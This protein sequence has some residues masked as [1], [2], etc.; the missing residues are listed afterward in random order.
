MF[1]CSR[2]LFTENQFKLPGDQDWGFWCVSYLWR[3]RTLKKNQER[4]NSL[5]ING[6]SLQVKLYVIKRLPAKYFIFLPELC[7]MEMSLKHIIFTMHNDSACSHEVKKLWEMIA[8][9]KVVRAALY[10]GS[11][12]ACKNAFVWIVVVLYRAVE[13]MYLPESIFLP[14]PYLDFIRTLNYLVKEHI[15]LNEE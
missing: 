13:L 2:S 9:L 10:N 15:F 11:Y 14:H 4:A 12:G 3:R 7:C 8:K 1:F 6:F 5:S